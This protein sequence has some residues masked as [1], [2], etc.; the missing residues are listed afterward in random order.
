MNE[1]DGK[2]HENIGR[3]LDQSIAD[4]H[5]KTV[6]RLSRMKHLALDSSRRRSWRW[7]WGAVPAS[8]VAI[9]LVFMLNGRHIEPLKPLSTDAID[10]SLLTEADAL[11]FYTEDLEFYLWLSEILEKNPDLSERR[12]TFPAD[13]GH[14]AALGVWPG[15]RSAS[16]YGFA[17]IPGA[18]RG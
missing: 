18:F 8:M 5:P 14:D 3:V 17:R 12:S 13:S 9:L 6:A 10:L 2:F 1:S 4:L 11:E 16:E 7:V 15:G